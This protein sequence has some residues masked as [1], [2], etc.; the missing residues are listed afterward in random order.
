LLLIMEEKG[1]DHEDLGVIVGIIE[2]RVNDILVEILV[3][4]GRP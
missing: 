2:G 1:H 3:R 4:A